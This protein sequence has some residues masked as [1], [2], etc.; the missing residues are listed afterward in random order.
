MRKK[1]LKLLPMIFILMILILLPLDWYKQIIPDKIN[2]ILKNA[3]GFNVFLK[4]NRIIFIIFLYTISIHI[5]S[6]IYN[7]YLFPIL[8]NFALIIAL[9][10]F[11]SS[12]YP[13][14][15][16]GSYF[17]TRYYY[18]FYLALILIICSTITDFVFI[19]R[20]SKK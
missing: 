11:P 19:I 7:N 14:S 16:V 1:I 5:F 15:Y 10:L 6:S 18:G 13:I 8:S 9:I 12:S 2:V 17:L 20:K 4:L 3:N